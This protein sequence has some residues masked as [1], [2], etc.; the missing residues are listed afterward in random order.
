V[1]PSLGEPGAAAR[2]EF[3][4]EPAIE[5]VRETGLTARRH[6]TGTIYEVRA[7]GDRQTYRIQLAPEGRRSQVL[8]SLESFSETQRTPPEKIRSLRGARQLASPRRGAISRMRYYGR[9]S[10]VCGG[11][12]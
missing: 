12:T 3:V 9:Y 11:R 7:D 6:L 8:L 10:G 2:A 1:A 4:R 5:D